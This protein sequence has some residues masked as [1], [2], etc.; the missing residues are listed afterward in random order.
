MFCG[1][2]W[3]PRICEDQDNRNLILASRYTFLA[4]NRRW[5]EFEIALKHAT[6]FR[7]CSPRRSAVLKKLKP[8]TLSLPTRHDRND[9][10]VRACIVSFDD[11]RTSKEWSAPAMAFGDIRP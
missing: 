6:Y 8:L 3:K 5:G 9:S 10:W 1:R 4:Q 7:T 11:S 2:A